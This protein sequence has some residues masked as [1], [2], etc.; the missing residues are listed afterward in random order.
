VV[1]WAAAYD[2]QSVAR[3]QA[4]RRPRGVGQR[5]EA[6]TSVLPALSA[7]N[8]YAKTLTRHRIGRITVARRPEAAST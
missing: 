5:A 8:G 7:R 1:A 6:E 4:A 3:A 2:A